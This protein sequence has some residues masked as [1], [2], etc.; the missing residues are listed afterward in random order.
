MADN[1]G[2]RSADN[3]DPAP[4][5]TGKQFRKLQKRFEYHFGKGSRELRELR[6]CVSDELRSMRGFLSDEI[7]RQRLE[8]LG[9]SQ[10]MFEFAKRTDQ[11]VTDLSAQVASLRDFL[12]KQQNQVRRLQEGYDWVI[13]KSF[14]LR[15]IR[16]I[17]DIEK[18]LNAEDM[19]LPHRQDLEM[20][21][22]ELVF[23][24]EGSGVEQYRPEEGSPYSGQEKTSEVT[25][26]D[27]VTDESEPGCISAVVSPGYVFWV[28]EEQ[29]RIVRP[30]KVRLFEKQRRR[31]S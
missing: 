12:S 6:T 1:P 24:L 17:D 29:Q 3:G 23:A 11:S 21:C 2:D 20:A 7:E 13:I 18:S 30:A 9:T 15:I 16:C 19:T 10:S 14:C 5:L 8:M 26:K 4:S 22:D 27:P 31:N 28:S 25:G